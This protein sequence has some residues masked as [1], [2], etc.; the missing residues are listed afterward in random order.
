MVDTCRKTK[1]LLLKADE[2]PEFDYQEVIYSY[3]KYVYGDYYRNYD[4]D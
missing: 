2:A 3:S 4:Y 1:K